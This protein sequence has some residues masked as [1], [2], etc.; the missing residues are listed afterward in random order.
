MRLSLSNGIFSKYSLDEN[1]TAIKR[2]GFENLEFNMKSVEENDED[3]VY[4]AKELIDALGL[5][6][7]TLHAATLHVKNESEI[8]KAIYYGRVSADFASKLSAP[9]LVIHSNVSRK[10]PEKL[11]NKFMK[12]IFRKVG[13]YAESLDLRLALE[14]LSYASSGFGKNVAELEEVLS[15]ID[16]GTVGITLDFCHAETSGQTHSL[17]EKY[18]SKLF[19]VHI[20]NRAHKPFVVE[21]PSLKTFLT[22]L[23]DYGYSGSLTIELSSKC[24]IAEVQKTKAVLEKLV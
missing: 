14:N 20:S 22:K 11:R 6:C 19:N 7:L 8:P 2:L 15:V 9:V 4:A 23:Q 24:A 21:T 10:L 18:H 5:H 17:L 1:L 16:E 3:S 13:S 12:E